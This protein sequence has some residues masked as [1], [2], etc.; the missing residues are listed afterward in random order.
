MNN[1]VAADRKFIVVVV[2]DEENIRLF[3]CEALTDAGFDVVEAQHADEAVAVLHA[4][5]REIHAMFTDIHMPGSIDGLALAHLS[6]R[7]WPWIALLIASGHARPKADEM[8]EASRFLAKP[9][10][11]DHVV[12]HLQDMLAM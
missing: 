10:H 11:P 1:T 2:E 7:T 8:P 5:A 4:R 9:Y 12:N 3:V 6:R